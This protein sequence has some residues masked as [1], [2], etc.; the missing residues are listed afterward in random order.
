MRHRKTGR[1]LNRTTSHRTAMF[2]NMAASLFKHELIQTTL[3]KAKDLRRVAER[4]ITISKN[5]TDANRRLVASRLGDKEAIKK[6]FTILGPRYKDRPG[7]YL[8]VLKNGYR[9]SDNAPMAVVALVDREGE[10]IA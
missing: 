4:L 8:R 6:L 1:K 7:G 3:P 9:K 2:R 10:E 5:N